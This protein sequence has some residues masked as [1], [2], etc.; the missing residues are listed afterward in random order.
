M[1]ALLSF[2]ALTFPKPNPSYDFPVG[3][4]AKFKVSVQF[5]GYIPLFGGKVG[6][7]DVVM[8]VKALAVDSK[9][10]EL[11]AVDSEIIDLKA[12]AFGT[13]LPLNKNN[14]GAFFPRAVAKFE[15]SGLV[16]LNDAAKVNMPV[17]LPGLDSQRLPEISYLPL[18]IDREAAS[19][20]TAYEFSRTFNGSV[21][22]YKVTPGKQDET[23]E[24]F[25][26]TV[27]QESSG[28][29]DAYGNPSP[30]EGAKSKLS[31]VLTGKGTAVFNFEKRMFD[32]VI[33]ETNGETEITNIKSGKKST[34][35]LKT[36]LTIT[37]D[38][39]KLVK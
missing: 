4:E 29:E 30:E 39:A 24:L 14:I 26:I 12:M 15:P 34:R 1:I 31:T 23:K 32:E 6:K 20:G 5:D 22:K 10:P 2:V 37:R 35:T 19:G 3:T 21:M 36:T 18:V 16:K 28:F 7:A 11:Q 17:K 9:L 27:S 13:T 38:G 8:M 33:V 25:D